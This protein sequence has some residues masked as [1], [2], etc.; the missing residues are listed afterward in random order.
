MANQI[1]KI[2]FPGTFEFMYKIKQKDPW[3]CNSSKCFLTNLNLW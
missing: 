3:Q 2:E 1:E